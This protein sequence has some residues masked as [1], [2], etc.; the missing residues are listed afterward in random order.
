MAEQRRPRPGRSS[1]LDWSLTFLL[2]LS[3]GSAAA[4]LLRDGFQVFWKILVEDSWLFVGILPKVFAGA[5]IGALIRILVP[6]KVI[7]RLIGEGS[8]FTGLMIATAAGVLFPG[9]PFTIFPLA[10]AFMAAGADRGA[11]LAFVTSWLLIGLNRMII[12][13]MPFLSPEVVGLRVLLSW[14]IPIL[15]GWMAR[16]APAAL[17]RGAPRS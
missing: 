8:G 11:A 16:H 2:V 6:K 10:V 14:P 7:G 17:L 5:L 13:E 12:W 4:V 3:T 9:G 15:V 1:G